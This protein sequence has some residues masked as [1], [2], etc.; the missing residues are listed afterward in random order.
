MT[1]D[2]RL[3]ALWLP[4]T[5]SYWT[6]SS[7]VTE[8]S[9]P[10]F[11]E[12]LKFVSARELHSH[13]ENSALSFLVMWFLFIPSWGMNIRPW[14]FLLGSPLSASQ[15]CL[16]TERRKIW[17]NSKTLKKG[18]KNLLDFYFQTHKGWN[19]YKI[20]INNSR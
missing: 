20:T 13:F 11:S 19:K 15:P 5:S 14:S 6:F 7:Q 10:N 9:W 3:V 4:E 8:W 2:I 12:L 16:T 17:S 18:R 1:V